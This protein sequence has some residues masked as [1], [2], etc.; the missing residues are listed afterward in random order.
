[1]ARDDI[2]VIS[3]AVKSLRDELDAAMIYASLAKRY[4]GSDLSR[5]LDEI[6]RMESRHALFWRKFLEAR[7]HDTRG[8][9]PS[10]LRVRLYMFLFRI[11]GLGLTLKLLEAGEIAAIETYSKL[12]ESGEFSDEEREELRRILADELVHEDEFIEEESRLKEFLEHVRDAVLGMS[13]GVV[14]VLSVSAGLAGAYGNPFNVAVGGLIVGIAG[15]LS[16]GIGS[17]T[18][19]K[20]Q[21][22]VRLSVVSRIVLAARYIPQVFYDRVKRYMAR[23]GFG[24]ELSEKIAREA[25]EKKELLQRIIAEEEYGVKEETLEK[26]GKA[27]LYTGLFYILGAAVP[28][29][30][31]FLQLPLAI[32]IPLSFIMAAAIM[33]L[34]GFLIA[35]SANLPIKKKMLELTAAGIGAALITYGIGKIASLLLNIEIE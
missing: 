20:A 27:G 8:I 22:E 2:D 21:R 13:D 7:G 24:E 31:Y 12:L 5:K 4:R 17:Y 3:V 9:A 6:A 10:R 25:V 28:L 18:S 33:A 15:A 26:P 14:E 16:M 23:K 19:V 32:A 34:T 35:V 29:T 30:P 1:M 11:L